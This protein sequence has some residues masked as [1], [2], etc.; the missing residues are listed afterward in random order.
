MFDRVVVFTLTGVQLWAAEIEPLREDVI[1][2]LVRDVLLPSKS[3]NA[4]YDSGASGYVTRWAMS[5]VHGFVV[6]AVLGR[7]L[8]NS[9]P[10]A[11]ALVH[12]LRDAFVAR[13]A[14]RCVAAGGPL[15][16]GGKAGSA[17]ALVAAACAGASALACTGAFGGFDADYGRVLD[18]LEGRRRFGED[19]QPAALTAKKG[20]AA[21]AA[22]APTPEGDGEG[23]Q[24]GEAAVETAG[25]RIARI[26]AAARAA[27]GGGSGRKVGLSSTGSGKKEKSKEE[28]S[29]KKSARTWDGSGKV[30]AQTAAALDRS[31]DKETGGAATDP[32]LV[33]SGTGASR[34]GADLVEEGTPTTRTKDW[35]STA[36]TWFSGITGGAPMTRADLAPVVDNLRTLLQGKN[37]ATEVADALC[38]SVGSALEGTVAD[39]KG[40]LAGLTG[41]RTRLA[42]AVTAALRRSIEAVLTPSA[43]VDILREVRAKRAAAHAAGAAAGARDPYVLVFCGVNGVG[44]STTLSK[45]AFYLKDHGHS[46]MLA[47]CDSFRAGAVEQLKKH[48]ERLSIDLHEAGYAKDPVAIAAEAIRRAKE[49][50]TDVVLVDTAGRMQ[51]NAQLML[52]LAKLVAVNAPD[53]VLFVGE[54]LVG[55][56]GVDQLVQFDASLSELGAAVLSSD[57]SRRTRID[58][59]VLTKFDTVDDKVGA[60]LSMTYK[61][62]IPIVF[63]GVGQQ[64]PDLRK[65]NTAAVVKALLE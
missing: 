52:Q 27:T 60:A 58:G 22:P 16:P 47:A 38:E 44:K 18:R 12:E 37:V 26:K 36:S 30:D 63:L 9:V 8:A 3:G 59:I 19:Q 20:A 54:A 2:G 49:A 46:V 55:N 65:L 31:R 21:T 29:G 42:E 39:G 61:T 13:F 23:E 24:E 43:P 5:N 51:N 34:S 4:A 25:A 17:A 41:G 14:D 10:Y 53:R 50:G 62:G 57:G 11:E 64:Y 6:A 1:S 45:I 32:A 48:A 15:S 40:G 33:F 35:L 7:S 28:D 56:D